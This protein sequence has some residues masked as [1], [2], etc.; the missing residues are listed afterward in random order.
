LVAASLVAGA[1]V[2]AHEPLFIV[3]TP[4][5]ITTGLAY[6]ANPPPGLYFINFAHATGSRIS[7]IGTAFGFDGFKVRSAHEAGA[8]LWSTPWQVL[9]ASWMMIGVA[10]MTH[11]T[12]YTPS[13]RVAA[14]FTGFINPGISPM[15]LSWNLG[16][17]LFAKAGLF[18][19]APLGTIEPG[20][21]NNGLGGTGAPLWTIEPHLA[22][23]Y[24]AD[25]WNL[26]ATLIYGISTRNTY[27]DV[28]NGHALNLDLTAT[29]RFGQFEIGP[30]GYL[31]TQVTADSG[32]ER[33]YGPGV[34]AYGSK[35]SVGGLIGYDFG[36]INMRFSVTNTLYMKNSFDGWRV[37]TKV[38][39]PLWMPPP[40]ATRR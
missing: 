39:V 38:S 34:C 37:W 25:G 18:I 20:P 26:T 24:L 35:A 4:P 36:A 14:R 5:G 40:A 3:N 10:G 6:A 2:R 21:F 16:G 1:P 17:G 31:S 22:V 27:S 33:F 9:G 15:M 23:S 13:D 7:G 28:V 8:V 32:C 11:F 30:I 12:L 19:W 29:K